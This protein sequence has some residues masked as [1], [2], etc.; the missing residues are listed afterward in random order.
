MFLKRAWLVA[1]IVKHKP[2]TVIGNYR[3]RSLVSNACREAS[4][5]KQMVCETAEEVGGL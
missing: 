1:A 4:N 2:I 3:D 5:G